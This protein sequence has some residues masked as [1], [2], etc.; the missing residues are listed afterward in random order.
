MYLA[1]P[2]QGVVLVWVAEPICGVNSVRV[3]SVLA[4]YLPRQIR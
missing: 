4:S 2:D 3:A 1:R